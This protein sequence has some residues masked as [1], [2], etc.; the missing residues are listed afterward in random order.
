[1]FADNVLPF[2]RGRVG[3]DPP[4]VRSRTLRTAN[5]AESALADRLGE[6]A[7]G[8]NGLSL[9]FLPGNDGV[10]LRVTCAGRSATDADQELAAACDA[11]RG[12]VG[13]YIY[14]E[15][16]EDLAAL[17]LAACAARQLTVAVA[18]SCTGGMLGMRL[19]AVP[20]ASAS[21]MG[22]VIA[23]DNSVK[24][25]EL[26]VSPDLLAQHGA[27]SKEV[28]RA[29]AAGV[30]HRFSTNVGIA[31]TGVAGPGGGTPEKP[32]GTVWVAV[33]LDGEIHAVRG[34]L[35]GDRAEIRWRAAQLGL[36]RL[37][38]ALQKDTELP[39][40]TARG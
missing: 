20:G 15:D 31:I 38:R 23:Y 4:V 16:D 27:V 7:R 40:W 11:I 21:F 10:D 19:T 33:D 3:E 9:A 22:G 34:T 32:V 24:I 35:P 5:I 17:T 29:M 2:F 14:G 1:M 12:R 8:V 28:A 37:R 18:E 36:D 6:L 25:R 26:D 30:R 13:R 39:A